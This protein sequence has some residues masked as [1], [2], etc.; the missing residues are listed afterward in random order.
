M[1][2][3]AVLAICLAIGVVTNVAV[4]WMCAMQAD[5]RVIR[6][7]V[8]DQS[9]PSAVE[10]AELDRFRAHPAAQQ[11]SD[12]QL[13]VGVE[14]RVGLERRGPTIHPYWQAMTTPATTE[15]TGPLAAMFELRVRSGWPL[16]ALH[17]LRDWPADSWRTST[18]PATAGE[19]PVEP[20]QYRWLW[21]IGSIDSNPAMRGRAPL[22][23]RFL[24]PLQPLWPGFAINTLLYSAL[25]W[26]VLFAPFAFRRAVRRRRNRCECCG[27]P[28]GVSPVC[29]ECGAAHRRLTT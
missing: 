25:A 27:Y 5:P 3:R 11:F 6:F 20:Y 18:V 19:R 9:K 16:L 13:A 17:G 7:Y 14:R 4:A 28:R 21:R 10:Q 15:W 22:A 23:P 26:L 24:L 8:L 29:S 2:F 1:R 12:D